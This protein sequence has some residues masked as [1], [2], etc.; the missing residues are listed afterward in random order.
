MDKGVAANFG[1]VHTKEIPARQ[2]LSIG[3]A[4]GMGDG[5]EFEAVVLGHEQPTLN[6]VLNSNPEGCNQYTG[7]N[8]AGTKTTPEEVAQAKGGDRNATDKI[9]R[10]NQGLVYSIVKKYARPHEAGYDD[11]AQEGN[12]GLMKAIESFDPE[13]G[14]NFSTHAYWKIKG[15][16][17]LGARRA[18]RSGQRERPTDFRGKKGE[19][20]GPA[21]KVEVKGPGADELKAA[22]AKLDPREQEIVQRSWGVGATYQTAED[23]GKKLGI[24]KQRVG[25][26]EKKAREKLRS[27]LS[28][29]AR[30]L[31]DRLV[32]NAGLR[33]LIAVDEA[34]C[35]LTIALG[36]N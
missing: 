14:T 32:V 16:V 23:I 24:T 34:L 5:G 30:K 27:S 18:R 12:I 10:D 29:N 11:L 36:S 17:S 15:Q 20:I 25:Q 22:I 1:K 4:T 3:G 26:I 31:M 8:C 33:P 13:K 6:A 21:E 19:D 9:V 35:G 2:I 7:P 28:T